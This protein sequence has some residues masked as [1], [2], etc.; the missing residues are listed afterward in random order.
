LKHDIQCGN[1]ATRAFTLLELLVVIAIIALLAGLLLPALAS[2]KARGRQIACSANLKQLA[3]A[4]QMYAGDNSGRLVQNTPFPVHADDSWVM[5]NV[6]LNNPRKTNDADIRL[7]LLF[8]YAS[9]VP[10]YH[11]PSDLTLLN[12]LTRDRS[13]SMNSWMG[14]RL[15]TTNTAGNYYEKFRTFVMENELTSPSTLWILAD[16][17]E[18]TIDDGWFLVTM[19]DYQPFASFPATRHQNGGM[20]SFADGHVDAFR[21]RDP[22]TVFPAE[23]NAPTQGNPKSTD[24]IRFKEIT[25]RQ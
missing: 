16:E 20:L 19:S 23:N 15:M 5:G 7:G 12:G 9:Q 14:S 3:L 21:F 24:W 11:C 25:T 13:Y 1:N 22:S 6:R 2:A 4:A 10:I 8:P 17:H 18:A